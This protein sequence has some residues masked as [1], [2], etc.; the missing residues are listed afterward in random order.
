MPNN[1]IAKNHAGRCEVAICWIVVAHKFFSGAANNW[2]P[3]AYCM[4]I[5]AQTSETKMGRGEAF[6]PSLFVLFIIYWM[7][8]SAFASSMSIVKPSIAPALP[9]SGEAIPGF[10][11]TNGA[12]ARATLVRKSAGAV[13][14]RITPSKNWSGV[15]AG[16]AEA[17][18]R[19]AFLRA[20]LLL[21]VPFCRPPRRSPGFDPRGFAT[22]AIFHLIASCIRSKVV[23]FHFGITSLP[24]TAVFVQNQVRQF[25][26]CV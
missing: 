7:S 10:P 18:E 17:T 20:V 8:R 2:T 22:F 14:S 11:C 25:V 12:A 9:T 19:A 24:R 15:I 16:S 21:G 6:C 5:R 13:G 3:L 4:E 26:C 23:C 1:P